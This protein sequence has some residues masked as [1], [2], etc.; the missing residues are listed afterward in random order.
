MKISRDFHVKFTCYCL[1]GTA[2]ALLK[3][4]NC[5]VL[6][7]VLVGL[8]VE[9]SNFYTRVL[10]VPFPFLFYFVTVCCR[11]MLSRLGL[12]ISLANFKLK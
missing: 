4:E 7:G 5:L 10:C 11:V 6:R 9:K 8:K 1:W 3:N 2:I 12:T